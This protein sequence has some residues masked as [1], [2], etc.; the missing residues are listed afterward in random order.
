MSKAIGAITK[1]STI[2]AHSNWS[3]LEDK[4]YSDACINESGLHY[5]TFVHKSNGAIDIAVIAFRG[6][7]NNSWS[8]SLQN[9][10]ANFH[11]LF[12]PTP[13]HIYDIARKKTVPLIAKLK[14]K[15]QSIK[16]YTT[17]HSLGGGIA[18]EIAYLSKGVDE[19]FAFDPSPVT[20]WTAFKAEDMQSSGEYSNIWTPKKEC[21]TANPNLS[22][23]PN[24]EKTTKEG[25]TIK[26]D[27]PIVHRIYHSYEV[28]SYI[29]NVID[30]I[31]PKHFNR[32]DYIFHYLD[33]GGLPAHDMRILTC[34]FLIKSKNSDVDEFYFRKDDISAL[35]SQNQ[36]DG[37]CPDELQKTIS[38]N[39]LKII[40]NITD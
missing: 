28:L 11:E 14:E 3:L 7:E 15:N 13:S 27:W 37:L 8:T 25:C 34:A 39:Q 18:Q 23:F 1:V 31:A 10:D 36:R 16:I 22:L 26:N 30:R 5:E 20:S 35:L 24:N 33:N 32:Y 19:V 17:G 9:W 38:G 12:F 21:Q 29:R 2:P 4:S 40:N 6:T